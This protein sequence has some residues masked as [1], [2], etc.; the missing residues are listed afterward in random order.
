MANLADV[1]AKS[2]GGQSKFANAA[3]FDGSQPSVVSPQGKTPGYSPVARALMGGGATGE[4]VAAAPAKVGRPSQPA[5]AEGA[6]PGGLAT[7][8]APDVG[9]ALKPTAETAAAVQQPA[10]KVSVGPDGSINIEAGGVPNMGTNAMAPVALPSNFDTMTVAERM[11]ALGVGDP[12]ELSDTLVRNYGYN[13]TDAQ[14]AATDVAAEQVL[15]NAAATSPMNTDEGVTPNYEPS[16]AFDA[17]VEQVDSVYGIRTDLALAETAK[18]YDAAQ[19]QLLSTGGRGLSNALLRQSNQLSR[20]QLAGIATIRQSNAAAA[21]DA[22]ASA[23]L[24]ERQL[25]IQESQWAKSFNESKRQFNLTY[26]ENIRQWTAEFGLNEGAQDALQQQIDNEMTR[27]YAGLEFDRTK[28]EAQV[29]QWGTENSLNQQQIDL[30]K[31]QLGAQIEQFAQTLDLQQRSLDL[32]EKVTNFNSAMG[33]IEMFAT[34][35]PEFAGN[36]IAGFYTDL[37]NNGTYFKDDEAKQ[38]ALGAIPEAVATAYVN[39]FGDRFT[40]ADDLQ[41]KIDTVLAPYIG[42]GTNGTITQTQA[43]NIAGG[44]VAQWSGLSESGSTV[45]M[46]EDAPQLIMNAVG[47]GV[48]PT[49]A[50]TARV[51]SYVRQNIISSFDLTTAAGRQDAAIALGDWLHSERDTLGLS[52]NVKDTLASPTNR[53]SMGSAIIDALFGSTTG[54]NISGGTGGDPLSF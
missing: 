16:A 6:T 36:L 32:Q 53:V 46:P 3:T 23:M 9:T 24:A 42:D 34:V 19:R 7:M 33:A 30:A 44:L 5:V 27:F 38:R 15:K 52:Q 49:A 41:A 29:Q 26:T 20:D 14:S 12:Q 17:Y 39:N 50:S 13:T 35:A 28:F 37:V 18:A 51:E 8:L 21:G 2:A 47:T 25:T 54:G 4:A 48:F 40:T 22:I 10:T 1:L 31:E 11:A 43:D 45:T